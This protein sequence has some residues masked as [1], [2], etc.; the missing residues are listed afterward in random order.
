MSAKANVVSPA[1]AVVEVVPN[2]S[3]VTAPVLPST[4]VTESVGVDS[5]VK[6]AIV[7]AEPPLCIYVL[8]SSDLT[9]TSPSSVVKAS[10]A[11]SLAAVCTVVN[12]VAAMLPTGS[13]P[14]T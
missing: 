10:C 2:C 12:A 3:V 5:T 4:L 7:P 6:S 13:I 9:T 1:S 11:D 14:V 8:A